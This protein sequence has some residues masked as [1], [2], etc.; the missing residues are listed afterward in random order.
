MDPIFRAYPRHSVD[1]SAREYQVILSLLF[2]PKMLKGN[3]VQQLESEFSRYINVNNSIAIPSARLGL[4]LILKY[5]NYPKGTE[6]IITPFT[7]W[8]IFTVIKAS[9][10][11]PVFCDINENTCNID[12]EAVKRVLNNNT[13]LLILTHMWGQTC[14][15]G[16]FMELKQKHNL[17]I[18]EDCAMAAGAEYLNRKAGSFGD[19]SIFSFGK[20]KTINAFGGGMLC[21]KDSRMAEYVRNILLSFHYEKRNML[22]FTIINSIIANILTRPRI[23]FFTLYP[24]LKF[25]N[26]RDPYN[27]IEHKRES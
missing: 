20:A 26:I 22:S 16:E 12:P 13:K 15:M 21:T 4:F 7:H 27:P 24:V 10:L 9:G 6:V 18:I 19:A 17:K 3:F 2:S 8:S 5:Y 1:I 11:K 25:L 23:F 14:N